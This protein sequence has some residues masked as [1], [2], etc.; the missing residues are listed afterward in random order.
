MTNSNCL[1]FHLSAYLV[2]ITG[3]GVDMTTRVGFFL[4]SGGIPIGSKIVMHKGS[5]LPRTVSKQIFETVS[6][7]QRLTSLCRSD[8]N[9]LNPP[10][11]VSLLR[12]PSRSTMAATTS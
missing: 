9:S 5:D 2:L 11:S 7:F 6:N 8:H 12:R 10:E 1:Q 3:T 4:S